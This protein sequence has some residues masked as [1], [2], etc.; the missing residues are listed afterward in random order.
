MMFRKFFV[1]LV[2][3]CWGMTSYAQ[4]N[5][6]AGGWWNGKVGFEL[7]DN[8]T[9]YFNPEIRQWDNFRSLRSAF[10][11]VGVEQKIAKNINGVVEYRM[12]SRN[13]WLYWQFRHRLSFGVETE[14]KNDKLKGVLTLRQQIAQSNF[15][16]QETMDLDTKTTTRLKGGIRYQIHKDLEIYQS[17][18]LFFNTTGLSYTN[19]RW[20]SGVSY[21]LNKRQSIKLGYLI[22][23]DLSTM[24]T[25]YVVTGG[26]SYDFKLKKDNVKKDGTKR[27]LD[28]LNLMNGRVIPCEVFIDTSLLVKVRYQGRY[29]KWKESEFHKN[30]IFSVIK[31]GKEEIIYERDTLLGYYD[32]KEELRIFLMGEQDARYRFKARHV[33][34]GGLVL[35]GALGFMGQDGVLTAI[36]P[37]IAYTLALIPGRIKVR[38]HH[39][40]DEALRYNDIY[41]DGFGAVA[42]SKRIT[43][44]AIGGFAGSAA[45]VLL[46]FLTK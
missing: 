33:F 23:R 21:D 5:Q 37:P 24:A 8:R 6:D 25:D 44:A 16:L 3:F 29:G 43:K 40:R 15:S 2:F 14:W 17:H 32:S 13:E 30:E 7:K 31:N 22:Q 28:Q 46:Y 12:G 41:G 34:W 9:I 42:K 35:C 4:Y 18:E 27:E 10:I 38:K 36:L 39:I 26:W 20:Q 19:W 1:I 45:G 11:D